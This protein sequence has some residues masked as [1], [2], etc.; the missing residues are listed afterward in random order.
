[1]E[2]LLPLER[3]CSFSDNLPRLAQM[4]F[5]RE[6]VTEANAHHGSAAQFR[7]GEISAARSIDL[8]HDFAVQF[9]DVVRCS[10]S[11]PGRRHRC[12]LQVQQTKTNHAH[13]DWRGELEAIVLFDPVGEQICEANLFAQARN[14]SG[15][16]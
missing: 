8:L 13:A 15:A 12:R 16:A 5:R 4:F 7:L 9:V 3:V 14:D 6:H 1:M 10:R 2:F 11:C